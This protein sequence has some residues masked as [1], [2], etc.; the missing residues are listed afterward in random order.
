MTAI[1]VGQRLEC[2]R[3]HHTWHSRTERKPVQCPKC[4]SPAWDRKPAPA[5]IA[6]PIAK[7]QS[8]TR[9]RSKGDRLARPA[10]DFAKL[11]SFG[12]WAD[13]TEPDEEILA[14]VRRGWE[15]LDD[16]DR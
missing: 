7:Y 4:K 11:P 9:R 16:P 1:N 10:I 13:R 14:E 6:E 3:C 15:A 2:K 8:S 5:S 12:S